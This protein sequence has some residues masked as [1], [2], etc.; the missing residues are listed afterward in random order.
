MVHMLS[1]LKDTLWPPSDWLG[2]EN[3]VRDGGESQFSWET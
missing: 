1:K 2:M 3:A